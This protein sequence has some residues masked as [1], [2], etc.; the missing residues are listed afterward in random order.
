MLY[1]TAHS[2]LSS[3]IDRAHVARSQMAWTLLATLFAP[4]PSVAKRTQA[5]VGF[6]SQA[7][8]LAG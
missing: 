5:P 8:P 2:T 4:K 3:H 1:P 6:P 7:A